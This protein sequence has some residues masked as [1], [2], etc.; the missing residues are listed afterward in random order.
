MGSVSCQQGPQIPQIPPTFLKL[1]PNLS[2]HPAAAS[3][4]LG[5]PPDKSQ[6]PFIGAREYSTWW[7]I[8]PGPKLKIIDPR[9]LVSKIAVFRVL[10]LKT[11]NPLFPSSP[12]LVEPDILY[13]WNLEWF[14]HK[15]ICLPRT[16]QNDPFASWVPGTELFILENEK[17]PFTLLWGGA[18][19]PTGLSSQISGP[20]CGSQASSPIVSEVSQEL[21]W[22]SQS[23]Q[24]LSGCKG[25]GWPCVEFEFQDEVPD[26]YTSLL[27][28]PSFLLWTRQKLSHPPH[29]TLW[30]LSVKLFW[31]LS[32]I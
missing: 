21:A 19:H 18:V 26:W 29:P 24:K 11:R 22:N 8:W 13:L 2:F 23:E 7:N 14:G 27:I 31:L 25:A 16:L 20:H 5:K 6:T 10:F 4:P 15:Q 30:H 28:C 3:Q 32:Y 12:G 9:D 17:I 1:S